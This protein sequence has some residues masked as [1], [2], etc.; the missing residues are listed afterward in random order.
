[1]RSCR[2]IILNSIDLHDNKESIQLFIRLKRM[3]YFWTQSKLFFTTCNIHTRWNNDNNGNNSNNSKS[4]NNP[5]NNDNNTNNSNSKNNDNSDNNYHTR[6]TDLNSVCLCTWVFSLLFQNVFLILYRNKYM[7]IIF[8][9]MCIVL[10]VLT[11]KHI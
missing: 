8:Q 5:N 3:M 7:S 6:Y 2:F 10:C 4:I 1:M 11:S 9:Q